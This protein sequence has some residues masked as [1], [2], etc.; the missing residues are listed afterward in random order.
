MA[1]STRPST[2]PES[3][4][5]GSPIESSVTAARRIVEEYVGTEKIDALI[6]WART[7]LADRAGVL[8]DGE[9]RRLE[10]LLESEDGVTGR[11]DA[12]RAAVE[13]VEET[14]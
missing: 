14:G 2:T 4:A 7:D 8:L 1:G 3:G 13:L 9:R 12:L 11:G 10:R 6:I 5:A